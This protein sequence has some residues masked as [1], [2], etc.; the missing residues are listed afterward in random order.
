MFM[1][2]T[3]RERTI[4]GNVGHCMLWTPLIEN[5]A[6]NPYQVADASPCSLASFF[7]FPYFRTSVIHG[8]TSTPRRQ[9]S[10]EQPY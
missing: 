5:L 10:V 1:V 8:R 6:N 7:R 9:K 4:A 2:F 3:S